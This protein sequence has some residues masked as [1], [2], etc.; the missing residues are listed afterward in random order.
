MRKYLLIMATVVTMIM[1]ASPLASGINLGAPGDTE[2]LFDMGNGETYWSQSP[3]A[4]YGSISS[5]AADNAGFSR[6][7]F[8]SPVSINDVSTYTVKTKNYIELPS[9]SRYEWSTDVF[10][11]RPISTAS[12]VVCE[13]RL[14]GW[15]TSGARSKWVPIAFVSGDPCGYSAIAW[16]F[17]P[18]SD[19]V[20]VATP[21][22]KRSWTM[23]RG[24]SHSSGQMVS[25]PAEADQE[26]ELKW[27]HTYGEGNFV[28]PSVLIAGDYAYVVAGGGPDPIDPL[29][30]VYCYDRFTGNEIW[31]KIFQRGAGYET[32]TPL[33]VGDFIYIPTT[34]GEVFKLDRYT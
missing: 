15:D 24:D 28:C 26:I 23:A 8:V 31:K 30:A 17:Y 18:N 7:S 21:D 1:M 11:G 5:D 10:V 34:H 16:G 33:I 19:T 20:P 22:H 32:A 27:H 4:T 25:E 14:Y 2:V 29:P 12:D 3:M 9:V 13:W 6:Y